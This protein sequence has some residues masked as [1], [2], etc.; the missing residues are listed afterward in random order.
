MSAIA[1]PYTRT[2]EELVEQ[3]LNA[4]YSNIVIEFTHLC[5]ARHSSWCKWTN[6]EEDLKVF[7]PR[8]LVEFKN[9][10]GVHEQGYAW[11]DRHVT[12]F[13]QTHVDYDPRYMDCYLTY[14][15][16]EIKDTITDIL[17]QFLEECYF[18][19]VSGFVQGCI[20]GYEEAK[21]EENEDNHGEEELTNVE[22][23]FAD[24]VLAIIEMAEEE[25]ERWASTHFLITE[26]FLEGHPEYY[27]HYRLEYI[28]LN[29]SDTGDSDSQE[30]SKSP[31]KLSSSSAGSPSLLPESGPGARRYPSP[32]QFVPNGG[33]LFNYNFGSD[34]TYVPNTIYVSNCGF[35]GLC[36]IT[37]H[38]NPKWFVVNHGYIPNY[39]YVPNFG[40]AYGY[41]TPECQENFDNQY[42]YVPTGFLQNL[43]FETKE[44]EHRQPERRLS[45]KQEEETWCDMSLC[46][47]A[48]SEIRFPFFNQVRDFSHE[49]ESDPGVRIQSSYPDLPIRLT[50]SNLKLNRDERYTW[51]S[52][53][54][55]EASADCPDGEGEYTETYRN[56]PLARSPAFVKPLVQQLEAQVAVF[57]NA[58]DSED[59]DA[60]D[61]DSLDVQI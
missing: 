8:F 28:F 14:R 46:P 40:D 21:N 16:K 35:K 19:M 47:K 12:R 23:N 18:T 37:G 22:Y 43:D 3:F 20:A 24:F 52:D 1:S 2:V 57:E 60:D 13:I 42:K 34:L 4:R 6:S 26:V 50:S 61:N 33:I 54:V 44:A 27:R 9:V 30:Y 10:N 15:D 11:C 29:R 41:I 39:V 5:L 58:D 45:I 17:T 59:E 36:K 38:L 51:P 25:P 56:A 53:T 31:S 55:F 48:K 7:L 32:P 49:L